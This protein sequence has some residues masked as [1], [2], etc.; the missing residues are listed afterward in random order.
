MGTLTHATISKGCRFP[1]SLQALGDI[2]LWLEA[3][4]K[5]WDVDDRALFRARVCVSELAANV[6][7]HGRVQS[8]D[9]TIDLELRNKLPALEIEISA[10]G[11]AFDPTTAPPIPLDEDRIGGRGLHL[12]RTYANSLLYR[13]IGQRNVIT[14]ALTPKSN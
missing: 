14:F 12:V 2:D 8:N 3:V 1:I 4:G 10:P 11:V 5:N 9:G 7:E 13:R 6:I